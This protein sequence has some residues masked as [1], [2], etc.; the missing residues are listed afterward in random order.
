MVLAGKPSSPAILAGTNSPLGLYSLLIPIG[1]NRMGAGMVWPKISAVKQG[2][3][4][5]SGASMTFDI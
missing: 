4:I 1:A 2:M 5:Y 3:G